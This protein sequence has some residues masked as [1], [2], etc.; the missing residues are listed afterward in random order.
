MIP[1]PTLSKT[2]D[3]KDLDSFLSRPQQASF[4]RVKNEILYINDEIM[5]T[6]LSSY[7]TLHPEQ[8]D[9]VLC[10]LDI[11]FFC[12]QFCKIRDAYTKSWVPF[13]LWPKQIEMAY[14]AQREKFV[15]HLKTRQSGA[16]WWWGG[17]K[18]TWDGIYQANSVALVISEDEDEARRIINKTRLR[19][20][21]SR[22]PEH[23]LG[24]VKI[25]D[26]NRFE[27]PFT[28]PKTSFNPGGGISSIRSTHPGGG[29]GQTLTYCML[30][31]ADHIGELNDIF[32]AVEPAINAGGKLILVST[33][34]K[35]LPESTYKNI[36][37]AAWYDTETD[38]VPDGWDFYPIF[39]SWKD[40]PG[41]DQV[42]YDSQLKRAL[43]SRLGSLD[44]LWANY[45]ETVEQALAPRQLNKRLP[46][47]HLEQ[48]LGQDKLIPN[49][50]PK[51]PELNGEPNLEVY[52]L[53]DRN[54]K[55]FIGADT[56]EGL[57]TSDNSAIYV[58]DQYGKDVANIVGQYNPFHQGALILKLSNAYRRAKALIENN[59]HGQATIGWLELNNGR[60]I[61]LK[62]KDNRK[63]GWNTNKVSKADMYISLAE[64]AA[65][66][67]MVINDK[68][69]FKELQSIHKDTLQA[70]DQ[71][72]DDRA[73]AFTLAQIAR[74]RA[75][76]VTPLRIFDLG[77]WTR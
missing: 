34:N 50:F 25:E 21:L 2:L 68:L 15:I 44:Q 36:F 69:A 30:D 70:P 9:F 39:L 37:R 28:H 17:V 5:D 61:L 45:P 18:P 74:I 13:N 14:A 16:T 12:Q 27:I 24:G 73:I 40:H 33:A 56:A 42:W 26:G 32:D 43:N 1:T 72:K 65:T 3:Q 38:E 11:I 7:S 4:N 53:P 66:K 20:M 63:Y 62:D 77:G 64:L 22:L 49:P 35:D 51:L 47:A 29:R 41:R 58:V 75:R 76:H 31:E 46:T 48:C 59:A 71:M 60:H 52:E 8:I 23:V 54:K 19:G 67:D 57:E 55:Y 6:I 10:K